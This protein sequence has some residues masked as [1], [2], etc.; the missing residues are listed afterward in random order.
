MLNIVKT[1][2]T[3]VVLLVGVTSGIESANVNEVL[4]GLNTEMTGGVAT[5]GM[6]VAN[7]FTLAVEQANASG[8]LPGTI[9]LVT[10]DNQSNVTESARVAES[11][12]ESGVVAMVG[13][14]TS[15]AALAAAEVAQQYKVPMLTPTA[16]HESV[17]QVGDYIFRGCVLNSEQ[18]RAMAEFAYHR[19]KV[20]RVAILLEPGE[21]YSSDL[22][23]DFSRRFTQLGG[24]IVAEEFFLSDRVVF[25]TQLNRIKQAHPDAIYIP[26]YYVSTGMIFPQAR[27]MGIT[28]PVLG[29]DGWDSDFLSYIAGA[30]NLNNTYYT[31]HL[32][33][34]SRDPMVET[35]VRA[36]QTKYGEVPDALAA[37]GYEAGLI[38]ADAVQRATEL[39]SV[40]IHAAL[41]E[42]DVQGFTGS[43]RF[44]SSGN[45]V[46]SVVIVGLENGEQYVSTTINPVE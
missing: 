46:K 8:G 13:P 10:L 32:S 26:H 41:R 7:G 30:T 12:I 43:I 33:P 16:I 14:T 11:L 6:S 42:T 5:F 45:A 28:I 15:G 37:L 34:A 20:R 19:L 44:D 36:Y 31:N 1:F 22:A 35:F 21:S 3:T 25:N 4:V 39:T 24:S 23:A 17:T 27:S 40:G 9:A 18:G 38:I 29:A 2:L